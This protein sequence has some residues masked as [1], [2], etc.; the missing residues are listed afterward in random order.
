MFQYT[1]VKDFNTYWVGINSQRL[2]IT[3]TNTFPQSNAN[4]ITDAWQ[5]IQDLFEA[6]LP[7]PIVQGIRSPAV[8]R[9]INRPLRPITIRPNP[10]TQVITSTVSTTPRPLQFVQSQFFVRSTLPPLGCSAYGNCSTTSDNDLSVQSETTSGLT[11][12]LADIPIESQ[13]SQ[14]SQTFP[15]PPLMSNEESNLGGSVESIQ[16]GNIPQESLD[17]TEVDDDEAIIIQ[18]LRQQQLDREIREQQRL[19]QQLQEQIRQLQEMRQQVLMQQDALTS[20][21]SSQ[22]FLG[23]RPLREEDVIQAPNDES[24]PFGGTRPN[25]GGNQGI[26]SSIS[27]DSDVD[28]I[29]QNDKDLPSLGPSQSLTSTPIRQN[30]IDPNNDNGGIRPIQTPPIRQGETSQLSSLGSNTGSR[31]FQSFED[32]QDLFDLDRRPNFNND[33]PNAPQT[34]RQT[35]PRPLGLLPNPIRQIPAIQPIFQGSGLQPISSI[36]TMGQLDSANFGNRDPFQQPTL[37]PQIQP[38]PTRQTF[39]DPLTTFTTTQPPTSR[40]TRRRM[41]PRRTTQKPFNNPTNF[42][43]DLGV[44]ELNENDEDRLLMQL[45][46]T[47]GGI[48]NIL[49]AALENQAGL[50]N[51]MPFNSL[52]RRQGR[53]LRSRDD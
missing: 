1:L 37:Q 34:I 43:I 21:Q 32:S 25:F 26:S 49:L 3:R 35:S 12:S 24:V 2:S 30:Q 36:P 39:N 18:V 11:E 10:A 33:S 45:L 7:A 6:G 51:Q 9:P 38:R 48:R 17:T 42:N 50:V 22:P 5:G 4:G 44:P 19:Q 29:I 31:P 14:E 16:S 13:E 20:S 23:G 15:G 8:S 46:L 52:F 53:R 41:R 28:P 40:P 47:S 27:D